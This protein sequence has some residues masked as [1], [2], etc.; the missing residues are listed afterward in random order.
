MKRNAFLKCFTNQWCLVLPML[1]Q[2]YLLH[3]THV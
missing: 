3:S 1:N 2:L